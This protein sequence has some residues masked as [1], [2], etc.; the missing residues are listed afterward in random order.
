MWRKLVV[1]G[2]AIL[3]LGAV[4]HA[5][6]TLLYMTAGDINM[7]ALAQNVIGPMFSERYPE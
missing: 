1:L 2:M 3:L 6:V 7:L 4:L 5:R